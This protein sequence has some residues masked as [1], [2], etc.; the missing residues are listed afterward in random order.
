MGIKLIKGN[1]PSFIRGF[2]IIFFMAIA[3]YTAGANAYIAAN[4]TQLAKQ[5]IPWALGLSTEAGL[6]VALVVG[7][8]VGNLTPQFAESLREACRPSFLLKSPLL[9]WAPNWA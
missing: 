8:L 5:G 3:C 7:I 6:I 4:P 2:S 9:S 1:V